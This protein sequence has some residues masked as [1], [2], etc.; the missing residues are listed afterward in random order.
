MAK[1]GLFVPVITL[2]SSLLSVF[3]IFIV[4]AVS[5]ISFFVVHDEIKSDPIKSL[6][7]SFILMKDHFFD[8]FAISIKYF[9]PILVLIIVLI[10][11]VVIL[12]LP[13]IEMVMYNP[14]VSEE[15]LMAYASESIS[16]LL[17]IG[18]GVIVIMILCIISIIKLEGAYAV[19]YSKLVD[20]SDPE[21]IVDVVVNEI[22]MNDELI[23]EEEIIVHEDSQLME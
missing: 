15:I 6:K 11:G 18:F 1:L 4:A 23:V 21:I 8:I 10:T 2:I 12:L 5:N 17:Y 14:Y 20:Q 13:M 3:I 9:W 16:T 22:I 7:D 19:L